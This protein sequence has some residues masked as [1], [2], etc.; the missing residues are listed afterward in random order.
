MFRRCCNREE[1]DQWLGGDIYIWQRGESVHI[2]PMRYNRKR[3][4]INVRE[5]KKDL[6]KRG[7]GMCTPRPSYNREEKERV[8]AKERERVPKQH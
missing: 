3:K 5:K 2:P 4:N 8:M 6:Q 7:E 1:R